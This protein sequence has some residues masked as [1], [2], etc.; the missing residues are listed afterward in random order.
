MTAKELFYLI[1]QEA[2]RIRRARGLSLLKVEKK[3][4]IAASTINRFENGLRIPT[5]RSLDK[6]V[7]FFSIDIPALF[8]SPHAQTY[9]NTKEKQLSCPK[10]LHRFRAIF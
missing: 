7:E 10:C 8:T 1:G 2:R 4:G 3:T 5:P 9:F 6:L